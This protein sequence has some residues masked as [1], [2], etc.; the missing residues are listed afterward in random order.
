LEYEWDE[1]K[2]RINQA[3]HGI[4]FEDA[5]GMGGPGKFSSRPPKSITARIVSWPSEYVKV[6]S[7]QSFSPGVAEGGD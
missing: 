1:R 7:S 2:R 4:D 6:E 3:T 5:I